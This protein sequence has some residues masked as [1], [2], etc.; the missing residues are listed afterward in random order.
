MTQPSCKRRLR[1]VPATPLALPSM[2]AA[3]RLQEREITHAVGHTFLLLLL[4]LLLLDAQPSAHSWPTTG[5][6]MRS[7][8]PEP[9]SRRDSV[10]DDRGGL[11]IG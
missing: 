6:H 5:A 2:Q 11:S 7:P 1:V 4:L 9:I 3:P 8:S 10:V